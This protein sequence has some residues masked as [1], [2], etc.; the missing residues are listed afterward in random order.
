M[1]IQGPD[2]ID[3]H[4]EPIQGKRRAK[5]CANC[6]YSEY[7]NG[8]V[9]Q[10][11]MHCMFYSVEDEDHRDSFYFVDELDVCSLWTKRQ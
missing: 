9:V 11:T 7:R 4:R 10:D 3:E 1:G 2:V 5:C 8:K 6:A